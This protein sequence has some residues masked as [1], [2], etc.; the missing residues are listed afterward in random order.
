MAS[1]DMFIRMVMSGD[2]SPFLK[3]V[4]SAESRFKGAL[5]G[6]SSRAARMELF[7]KLKEDAKTA[8]AEFFKLKE[9]TNS[10]QAALA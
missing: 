1:N 5:S 7:D 6:M 10:Y 2:A 3:E 4:V 9:Q 8:A